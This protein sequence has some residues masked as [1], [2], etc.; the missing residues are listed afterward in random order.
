MIGIAARGL[1]CG[2]SPAWRPERTAAVMSCARDAPVRHEVRRA[3]RS[4]L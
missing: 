1:A 2:V 4:M 3:L